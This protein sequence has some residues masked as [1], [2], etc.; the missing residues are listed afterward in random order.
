MFKNWFADYRKKDANRVWERERE[1]SLFIFTEENSH[2]FELW[3]S[4]KDLVFSYL[5]A[6]IYL[7][8]IV[9]FSHSQYIF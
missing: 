8:V 9:Y 6:S 2:V 5:F 4:K 1:K 7:Y 3:S